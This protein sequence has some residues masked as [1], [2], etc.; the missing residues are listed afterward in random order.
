MMILAFNP[1]FTLQYM[2]TQNQLHFEVL[3]VRVGK[4]GRN[5]V[6]GPFYDSISCK[7]TALV[8]ARS[9]RPQCMHDLVI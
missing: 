3:G 8:T 1:V 7:I 5:H 6:P 4:L 2:H 9:Q